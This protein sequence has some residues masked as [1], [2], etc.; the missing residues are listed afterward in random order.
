[1]SDAGLQAERTTLAWRRTLILLMLVA[2]LAI[3][4]FQRS[5]ALTTA[6]VLL[7]ALPALLILLQ[8]RRCYRQACSAM[9]GR[10][11]IPNPLPPLMLTLCTALLAALALGVQA[12]L[13]S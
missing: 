10:R 7:T 1:M 2:G 9:E 12:S 11:S 6:L 8:Q 3:R 13:F 5:P 4:C